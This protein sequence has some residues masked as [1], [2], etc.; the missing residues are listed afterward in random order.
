MERSS[1]ITHAFICPPDSSTAA[2]SLLSSPTSVPSLP[3]ATTCSS[4][5]PLPHLLYSIAGLRSGC[6]G[7]LPPSPWKQWHNSRL[8]S[9]AAWGAWPLSHAPLL[10]PPSSRPQTD[11]RWEDEG[12]GPKQ[13]PAACM[14]A[15]IY[16]RCVN[17]EVDPP[18]P[19][20]TFSLKAPM[21]KKRLSSSSTADDQRRNH[22]SVSLSLEMTFIKGVD[23]ARHNSNCCRGRKTP[24]LF[25]CIRAPFQSAAAL[26]GCK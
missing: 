8:V 6:G 13:D 23:H 4:F 12:G 21:S 3:S 2:P 24:E 11:G 5:G 25:L 22:N 26:I 17:V 19:P 7:T 18:H 10:C 1:K 14:V 9:A 15:H 20:Q 16:H